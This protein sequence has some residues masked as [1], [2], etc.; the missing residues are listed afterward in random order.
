MEDIYSYIL[1]EEKSFKTT[2]V[3]VIDG[4]DFE[5]YRHIKKSV[6]YKYGQLEKNMTENT[7]VE[8]IILPILNVA[9]RLEDVNVKDIECYVNDPKNY[10]LSF[11]TRKFHDRWTRKYE[12]DTFIDE[13]KDSRIDFGLCLVKNVNNRPENVP[14]QRLAFCDQTD[15]L[16]GPICEKH[17]YSPDQLQEMKWDKD[18]IEEAIVMSR[19][20]KS[21]QQVEGQS[22]KTPGRYIEVYELHGVLR[23][24]WLYDDGDP[25]KYVR[26]AQ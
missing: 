9:Y 26:Q 12:I 5:M 7:P 2:G 15:I 14:L 23:E 1:D 16:S 3:P 4:W 20:E 13:A 18:K 8:N 21:N 11:F 17:L 25:D 24:D 22:A 10:H 6:L 19:A